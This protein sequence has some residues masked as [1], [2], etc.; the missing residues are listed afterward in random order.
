MA[1]PNLSPTP[2]LTRPGKTTTRHTPHL[3]RVEKTEG[4]EMKVG[5][6]ELAEMKAKEIELAEMKVKEIEAVGLEVEEI[7]AEAKE[8]VPTTITQTQIGLLSTNGDILETFPTVRDIK[9]NTLAMR[10][11]HRY[12]VREVNL[13]LSLDITSGLGG[14]NH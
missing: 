14:C 12:Q 6:I 4:E 1:T 7:E 8:T 2:S 13:S 11:E 3:G 9:M 5:E 10:E